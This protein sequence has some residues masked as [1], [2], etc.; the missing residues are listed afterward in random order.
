MDINWKNTLCS[1]EQVHWMF[2]VR[3]RS[4]A[5]ALFTVR[6]CW[7]TFSSCVPQCSP[8]GKHFLTPLFVSSLSKTTP[9]PA[10]F[11]S[12]SIS[13]CQNCSPGTLEKQAQQGPSFQFLSHH[14]F[15][16][17][18]PHHYTQFWALSGC[19]DCSWECP[20]LHSPQFPSLFWYIFF[21]QPFSSFVIHF[22]K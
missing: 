10:T 20:V 17:C 7:Y 18:I 19:A 4:L 11:S 14:I 6:R 9:C 8:S 13:P 3:C 16:K 22:I 2:Q 1:S 12:I 15:T 5:S 21:F